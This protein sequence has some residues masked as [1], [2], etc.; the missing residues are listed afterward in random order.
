MK[1]RNKIMFGVFAVALATAASF[2]NEV[3]A[4]YMGP[5]TWQE[6]QALTTCQQN[7]STFIAFLTSDRENCL[8]RLRTAAGEHTGLWSRH[9]HS[10]QKL[11]QAQG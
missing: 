11:A 2:P 8:S 3:G 7:N 10:P 5:T 4:F 1:M 9:D 6:R